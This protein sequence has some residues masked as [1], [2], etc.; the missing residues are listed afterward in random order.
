MP[1]P[2][3]LTKRKPSGVFWIRL[4]VPKDV[5]SVVGRAE[6]VESLGTTDK[7][8]A[9]A[10]FYQR[11]GEIRSRWHLLASAGSTNPSAKQLSAMA[12]EFYRSIV[13]AHEEEP[14]SVRAWH[15]GS[16][17]ELPRPAKPRRYM[18]TPGSSVAGE[19]YTFLEARGFQV[20][21]R[22]K[23]ALQ[24]FYEARLA[25]YRTLE[26]MARGSTRRTSPIP[27]IRRW[28]CPC[29]RRRAASAGP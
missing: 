5:R 9:E 3:G 11:I 29:R 23:D 20:G 24:R 18:G 15:P 21:D 17:T 13:A 22:Y 19:M 27:T 25:A 26:G 28:N 16:I 6:L 14:G 1:L 2:T 4:R 7:A 10:I 12:G 8:T